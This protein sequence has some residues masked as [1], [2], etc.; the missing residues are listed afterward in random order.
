[1]SIEKDNNKTKAV[2]IWTKRRETKFFSQ[3]RKNQSVEFVIKLKKAKG[4]MTKNIWIIIYLNE[5]LNIKL[6]KPIEVKDFTIPSKENKLKSPDNDNVW[7]MLLMNS[8]KLNS[9]LKRV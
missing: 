6:I 7:F 8:E 9:E 2:N 4:E 5:L 3:T 1:M